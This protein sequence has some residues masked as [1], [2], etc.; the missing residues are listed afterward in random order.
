MH[1]TTL[2]VRGPPACAPRQ[3][4]P[5][6]H[7]KAHHLLNSA[8]EGRAAVRSVRPERLKENERVAQRESE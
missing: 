5:G 6:S 3:V 8:A 2:A 7:L 1:T 4:W